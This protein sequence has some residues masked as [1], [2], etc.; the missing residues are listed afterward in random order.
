MATSFKMPQ[1]F[2]WKGDGKCFSVFEVS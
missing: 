1:D 2:K